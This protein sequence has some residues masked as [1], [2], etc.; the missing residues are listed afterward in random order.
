[1]FGDCQPMG[2]VS[3]VRSG[4]GTVVDVRLDFEAG[5]AMVW[6]RF[7]RDG[8]VAGLRL[9]PPSPDGQ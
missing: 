8:K 3:P 5:E 4:V 9:R 7:D 2:D 1:M 6:I